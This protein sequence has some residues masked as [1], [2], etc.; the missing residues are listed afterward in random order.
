MSRLALPQLSLV[1]DLE[2]LAALG[3]QRREALLADSQVLGLEPGEWVFREGETDGDWIYLLDGELELSCQGR[4]MGVVAG[5]TEQARTPLA[6]LTPRQLSA[7]TRT[8]CVVLRIDG[9]TVGRELEALVGP[10]ERL[11]VSHID[12][13]DAVDWMT[14]MLKSQ[15]FARLPAA[16]IQRVFALLEHLHLKRGE[17]VI[18][19][20][21]PGDA[22]YIIQSGR[23]V[24]TRTPS[25]FGKP[26]RLSELGEGDT[27]GEEALLSDA[28]R[29]ATVT[30]ESDGVLMR[31]AKAPFLD[32][33]ARPIIQSVDFAGA[34]ALVEAG[35]LWLDVR[36]PEEHRERAL[37][38][39]VNVPVGAL[40]M[41]APR[42]G[43]GKPY[44]VYC[45]N[46]DRSAIGTF[47]LVQHGI[48]AYHLAGGLLS[49]A[50]AETAYGAA[51][52][53]GP[54]DL[55]DPLEQATAA[56]A[57]APSRAGDNG[58]DAPPVAEA[59]AVGEPPP[60]A[61][62]RPTGEPALPPAVATSPAPAGATAVVAA[63]VPASPTA[64]ESDVAAAGRAPRSR[65]PRLP[66]PL[67]ARARRPRPPTARQR[68]RR[69]VSVPR[70]ATPSSP[71]PR[72]RPPA[73]A[74]S[75]SGRA[76]SS[77]ARCARR[78]A[79]A[80]RWTRRA[81][82]RRRRSSRS[83]AIARPWCAAGPRSSRSCARRRRGSRPISRAPPR[84]WP[85]STGCG[86]RPSSGCATSSRRSSGAHG[87]PSAGW[88]R[89][90][91]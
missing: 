51:E 34:G 52:S 31:L 7:R 3:S 49:V 37:P 6:R 47:L 41:R 48:E 89:H 73:C 86:S 72:R 91:G 53:V 18:E 11:E 32:L 90:C 55:E 23:C 85:R 13:D 80:R 77:R 29:N 67:A 25:G 54:Q 45:D 19:Q 87:R 14:R 22:Y 4:Q 38:A 50:V 20:G 39:S 17:V 66:R 43:R 33:V 63:S 16:N 60:A 88:R 76:T 64:V 68:R 44:I 9:R 21:G 62:A 59:S 30:M 5:G 83:C 69:R 36:F 27:F 12:D 78:S 24:V 79:C 35:A 28:P 46:G 1:A 15:L 81:R 57:S 65:S 70:P 61:P 8:A 40:R 58:S 75:S 71:P 56:P 84:S 82:R 26:I 10:G 2:P 42:L 74:R